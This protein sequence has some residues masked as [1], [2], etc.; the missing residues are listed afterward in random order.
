VNPVVT[1]ALAWVGNHPSDLLAYYII[2]ITQELVFYLICPPS[3][4]SPQEL[5]GNIR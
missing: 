1:P 3:S 4:L 5:G 2:V